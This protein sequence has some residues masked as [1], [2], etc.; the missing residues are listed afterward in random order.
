MIQIK[1][2]TKGELIIPKKIRE[3]LG[4]SRGRIVMIEVKDKSIEIHAQREDIASKWEALAKKE[5]VDVG[6]WRYGDE[7]YEEI[8]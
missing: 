6:K 5:R 3:H 8:F 4:L 7:L 1:L 2:G